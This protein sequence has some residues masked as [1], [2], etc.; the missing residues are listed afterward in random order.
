MFTVV[1]MDSSLNVDP[2]DPSKTPPMT[3]F[4]VGSPQMQGTPGPS[5][6][7]GENLALFC[8]NNGSPNEDSKDSVNF[9]QSPVA[10]HL[11]IENR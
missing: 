6:R 8:N 10:P 2:N 11:Q 1:N 9:S 7:G 3:S 5:G 4:A